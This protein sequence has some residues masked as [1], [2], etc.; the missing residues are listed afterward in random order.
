[1]AI[2]IIVLYADLDSL[3]YIPRYSIAGLYDSSILD[4]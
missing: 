1:M 2:N 4:V 3:G